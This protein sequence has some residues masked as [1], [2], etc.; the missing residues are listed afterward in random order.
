MNTDTI[1][2]WISI[3]CGCGLLVAAG[4]VTADFNYFPGNQIKHKVRWIQAVVTD[5]TTPPTVTNLPGGGPRFQTHQPGKMQPGL[6][7]I[8]SVGEDS[9]N[10]PKVV[11]AEGNIIHQWRTDWF[12]I[13]PDDSGFAEKKRPKRQPGVSVHGIK[14]TE[15]GGIV[16]N[17]EILSTVRIDACSNVQWK[18]NNRGHHFVTEDE[19]GDFW[20]GGGMLHPRG[21]EFRH[22]NFRMPLAE[23]TI[24]QL[25]PEGEVKREIPIL[26]ILFQ[27]DLHGLIFM[28]TLQQIDT[29]VGGDTIHLND[30]EFFPSDMEEGI[31][32]HGDMIMSL[33][34]NHSIIVVDP[35]TLEIKHRATG[36][37]MRQHDPDFISGDKYIVFDNQTMRYGEGQGES[38]SRIV[39]VTASPD[40][41]VKEWREVY[42]PANDEAKFYT[43]AMGW[44]QPLDNG[45]VLAVVSFDGRIV[46]LDS[47][48]KLV[49]EYRNAVG[50]NVRGLVSEGERLPVEMDADWFAQKRA[51]AGC[52]TTN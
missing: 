32:K 4:A 19:N 38:R 17:F 25:S 5:I 15:D 35:E 10:T 41:G 37:F 36:M 34:N 16:F 6:T 18:L 27:N 22:P 29:R 31:F 30:V 9:L 21:T 40:G 8:V 14:I 28:G 43:R 11:D 23:D 13:W 12:E 48:G 39:E 42:A 47:E 2:R 45:N 46:E 7:L 49:W 52:A 3:A 51:A 44:Q 24:L 33:R 20:V 26:D 50:E 1:M